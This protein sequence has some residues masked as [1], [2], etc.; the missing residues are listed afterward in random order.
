[1]SV[2]K[3]SNLTA[4]HHID[5]DQRRVLVEVAAL[6]HGPESL[7]L[8][9]SFDVINRT[10]FDGRVPFPVIQWNLTP[11][12]HCVGQC[13]VKMNHIPVITIHP[14]LL[15]DPRHGEGST[16]GTFIHEIIH[17]AQ[18]FA[19]YQGTKGDTSHNS[20]SWVSEVNRLS[21][22]F[23]IP[24]FHRRFVVSGGKRRPAINEPTASAQMPDDFSQKALGRWPHASLEVIGRNPDTTIVE[25]MER[26]G[27]PRLKDAT[28]NY[29][30]LIEKSINDGR[31]RTVNTKPTSR[32][33]EAT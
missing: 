15:N 18:R 25:M 1:M 29:K 33:Q 20:T 2:S 14:I 21:P 27:I 11:Y 10:F 31:N 8:Y 7:W 26:Y 12:G 9:E 16:I 4:F 23:G 19:E 28:C 3:T 6:A 5:D 22:A 30:L 24:A 32:R 17:V 13:R